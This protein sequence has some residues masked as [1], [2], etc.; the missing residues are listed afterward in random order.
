MLLKTQLDFVVNCMGVVAQPARENDYIDLLE[1][2]SVLPYKL[3]QIFTTFD[4]N[5]IQISSD[6]VFSGGKGNYS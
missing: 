1:V 4:T 5:L 6:G 3:S 2:N